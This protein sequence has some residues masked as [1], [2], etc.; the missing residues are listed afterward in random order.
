MGFQFGPFGEKSKCVRVRREDTLFIH[1]HLHTR[2]DEE[3][4]TNVFATPT[5]G[6]SDAPSSG[7]TG[8]RVRARVLHHG[9]GKVL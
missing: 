7:G 8:E 3:K 1:T 5:T 2:K 4:V 6:R 9:T